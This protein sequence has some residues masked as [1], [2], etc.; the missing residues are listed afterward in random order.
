MNPGDRQAVKRAQGACAVPDH[1]PLA[2][3]CLEF[4]IPIWLDKMDKSLIYSLLGAVITGLL[5]YVT[6]GM[7]MGGVGF[8]LGWLVG[9]II[10]D[11]LLK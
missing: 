8:V 7:T 10:P 5:L 4:N 11:L 2:A 3:N 6:L 9:G 1:R